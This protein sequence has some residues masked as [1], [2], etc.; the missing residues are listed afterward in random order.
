MFKMI[1]MLFVPIVIATVPSN[2]LFEW[3]A[4]DFN[5]PSPEHRQTAIENGTYVIENNCLAGV[6]VWEDEYFVTVP[7]WKTGVPVTLAKLVS[8]GTDVLLDAFPSWEMQDVR[9]PS[10]FRFVQ[11]MEIDSRGWMWILDAGRL[12]ILES[13][14][15][16]KLG[17][18]LVIFDLEQNCTIR[19]FVFPD[20]VLNWTTSWANDVVVDESN[21]F[22][23]ITDTNTAGIGGIIVYD[24][25]KNLARRFEDA[26]SMTPDAN[27][28]VTINN[29]TYPVKFPTD[30][31]A[32]SHDSE[33]LYY[34]Q[35]SRRELFAVPTALL[36]NFT[37]TNAEIA[38]EVE[39]VGEKGVSDGMT[40]TST[41]DVI[42]GDV[43]ESAVKMWSPGT[44]ISD[45]VTLAADPDLMQWPDTFAWQDSS[46]YFVS[47]R[48]QLFINNTMKF[49]GSDGPNFR[50][51]QLDLSP[52][53]SYLT[54]APNPVNASCE[55]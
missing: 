31:I 14:P 11:S 38:D 6:K 48:L 9:N 50:I 28:T 51:W 42:F 49:D 41:G 3:V 16:N 12:D 15:I 7:R 30:G 5:W 18:K 19:E 36:R 37:L 35:L 43:E 25:N 1:L 45:A 40:A 26:A 52:T 53:T 47:N 8:N 33:T 17:P 2:L 32:L 29:L 55:L 20:R 54:G 21:G 46:V 24:F 13:D 27:G 34:C 10:A 44:P 23:Y 4:L 22:A 39:L